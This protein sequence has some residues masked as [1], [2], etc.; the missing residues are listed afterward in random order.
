MNM[1]YLESFY[2]CSE[3][4]G[5]LSFIEYGDFLGFLDL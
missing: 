1:D 3:K 5:D 2:K 4:K